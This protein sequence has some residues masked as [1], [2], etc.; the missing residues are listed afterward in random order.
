MSFVVVCFY[1]FGAAVTRGVN[2]ADKV[3]GA[4]LVLVEN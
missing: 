2:V 1:F 4:V 3:Q